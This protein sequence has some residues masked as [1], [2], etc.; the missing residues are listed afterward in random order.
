RR[1]DPIAPGSARAC[2]GCRSGSRGCATYATPG[3]CAKTA[4]RS[5]LGPRMRRVPL[6]LKIAAFAATLVAVA[7]GLLA[8]FTVI[9]PW[10][11]KLASQDQLAK[12]L[13]QTA[14]PAGVTV[15]ADGTARVDPSRI[16]DMVANSNRTGVE[17]VFAI[18]RDAKGNLDPGA[19]WVNA[20]G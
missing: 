11:A 17:I 14:L 10:R 18:F 12:A 2:A 19:S 7:V 16:H 5:M 8:L 13:V 1:T 3:S 15:R 4:A 20:R 6:R 9:L